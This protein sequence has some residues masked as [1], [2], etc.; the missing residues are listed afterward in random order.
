MNENFGLH[1][2]FKKCCL[3]P[4]L[5]FLLHSDRHFWNFGVN[6]KEP[7]LFQIK[8]NHHTHKVLVL[9]AK[10]QTE[11]LYGPD[12]WPLYAV[13][14]ILIMGH[15]VKATWWPCTEWGLADGCEKVLRNRFTKVNTG[16][17]MICLALENSNTISDHLFSNFREITEIWSS[18][19]NHQEIK[20]NIYI[21]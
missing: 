14:D 19:G 7:F 9:K 18:L 16:F 1:V 10:G 8:I 15:T 11:R 6:G 4:K 3:F 12:E 5:P 21:Y 20:I 2:P 13:S 17:R